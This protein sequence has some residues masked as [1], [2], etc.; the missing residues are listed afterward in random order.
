[1]GIARF[2]S[3]SQN[4]EEIA[5]LAD[6]IHSPSL[7]EAPLFLLLPLPPSFSHLSHLSPFHTSPSFRTAHVILVFW[8]LNNVQGSTN[9]R[10]PGC[11]IAAGKLRQ[12]W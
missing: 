12:K 2:Y 7:F 10:A 6:S 4:V 9:R 1:M 5:K 3:S 11:V 8:L